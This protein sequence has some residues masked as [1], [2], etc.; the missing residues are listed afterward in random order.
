MILISKEH[1]QVFFVKQDQ[2]F[3]KGAIE[4]HGVLFK[5][6][7]MLSRSHGEAHRKKTE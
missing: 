3:E 2:T 5:G 6:L 1:T 4:Q 7:N